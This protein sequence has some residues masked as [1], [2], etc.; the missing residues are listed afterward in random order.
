MLDP[1][2][3]AR[4]QNRLFNLRSSASGPQEASNIE[5]ERVEAKFQWTTIDNAGDNFEEFLTLLDR[6]RYMKTR[7]GSLVKPSFGTKKLTLFS[8]NTVCKA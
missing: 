1:W 4:D 8:F 7:F 6:I 5:M 3:P 2:P